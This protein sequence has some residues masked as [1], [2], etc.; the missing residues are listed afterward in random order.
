M[1]DNPEMYNRIANTFSSQAS[2]KFVVL[3]W[4]EKSS[5]SSEVKGRPVYCYQE[6]VD[7]GLESRT[8]LLKSEDASK[9][10]HIGMLTMQEFS[11]YFVNHKS[12][13]HI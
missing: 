7:M 2:I 6:I 11:P 5:L 9:F 10:I 4:G 8:A 13:L 12:R 3:L 1:V